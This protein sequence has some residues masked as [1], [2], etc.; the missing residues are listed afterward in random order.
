MGYG[1]GGGGGVT[2]A[3]TA[4]VNTVACPEDSVLTDHLIG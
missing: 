2:A 3:A 1:G 4:A